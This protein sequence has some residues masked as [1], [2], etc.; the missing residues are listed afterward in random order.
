M[1]SLYS[2][3]HCLISLGNAPFKKLLLPLSRPCYLYFPTFPKSSLVEQGSWTLGQMESALR[4][5]L[6]CVDSFLQTSSFPLWRVLHKTL[7]RPSPPRFIFT[8]CFLSLVNSLWAPQ[9]LCREF[10]AQQ[11]RTAS[12]IKS[13]TFQWLLEEE[14]GHNL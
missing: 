8:G 9:S 13:A 4:S 7:L 3:T 10:C 11:Q 1:I 5:H 6:S 12:P 2:Y 14:V